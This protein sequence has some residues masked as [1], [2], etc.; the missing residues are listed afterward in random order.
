MTHREGSLDQA[1]DTESVVDVQMLEGES[2]LDGNSEGCGKVHTTFQK[3]ILRS[4]GLLYST[5][6]TEERFGLLPSSQSDGSGPQ[7]EGGK[8][9]L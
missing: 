4:P 3:N 1:K 9:L 6:H 7:H 2:W 8:C 5:W